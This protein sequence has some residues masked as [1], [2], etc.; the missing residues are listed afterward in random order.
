MGNKSSQPQF[1]EQQ[2]HGKQ[3]HSA[4]VMPKPALS[5]SKKFTTKPKKVSFPYY[6]DIAYYEADEGNRL[7]R[8]PRLKSTSMTELAEAAREMNVAR[9][10]WKKNPY[11]VEL[12]GGGRNKRGRRSLRRSRSRS[13]GRYRRTSRK[14]KS[15]QSRHR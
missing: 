6:P 14:R 8:T 5:H 10:E 4:Y 2:F 3:F 12:S 1:N 9:N 13:S 11:F 15:R 7:Y